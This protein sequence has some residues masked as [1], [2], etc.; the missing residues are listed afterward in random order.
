M[1]SLPMPTPLYKYLE[2]RYAQDLI[3]E[4]CIKLGTL[5]EYRGME[6]SDQERGDAHEGKLTLE[7]PAGRHAYGGEKLP[8][9][10]RNSD[11][12]IGPG[13]FVT[14]GRGA[15]T[16]ESRITDLLI[17]CTME[18]YDADYGPRFGN[19]KAMACVRIDQPEQFF[20]AL[21]AALQASMSAVG[22]P[23]RGPVWGRCVYEGHQHN[24]EREDLPDKRL[25]KEVK[26][27]GQREVRVFWEP[28][29]MRTLK[30]IILKVP[31]LT[32]YCSFFRGEAS[33]QSDM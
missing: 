2:P 7:S 28:V 11:V 12:R 27:Q 30:P 21:D 18:A 26:Y 19:G 25:L 32:P 24:W 14:E 5:S 6:G 15:I 29:P 16:I 17:Y 23:L 10:L 4:G 1:I 22:T 13:A 8:P 31:A 3:S 33:A 20:L 9:P